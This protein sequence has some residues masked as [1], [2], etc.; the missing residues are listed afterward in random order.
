MALDAV[1]GVALEALIARANDYV[2]AGRAPNTRKAYRADWAEFTSWAQHRGLETLPAAPTTVA[3]YLTDL[4]EVAKTSTVERRLASIAFA[5]RAAGQLSPTDDATV[6]A[7][8]A[9]IRRVHGTAE[10]QAA[11]ISIPLLRRMIA[12]LP[13]EPGGA[14]T[15]PCCSSGS[16]ARSGAASSSPST[17]P[18]SRNAMKASS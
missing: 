7:V 4:A 18:T 5:H 2:E 17:S 10:D 14:G 8:W 3:L 9:G 11:P 13:P 6:K 1:R 15:P 16:P 12:A